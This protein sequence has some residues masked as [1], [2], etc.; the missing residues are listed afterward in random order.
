MSDVAL[1]AREKFSDPDWT[2][3]GERRARVA[4]DQ[5]RTLWINTGSLCNIECRNCYI[6]SSPEND[7]LAYITAREAARF[8]E[9]IASSRLPVREIG[10]TGGEPFMNPDIIAMAEDALARGHEVLILTNA[11]QP[12]QRPRLRSGLLGVARCLWRPAHAPGEPRPLHPRRCTRRSAGREHSPRRSTASTGSP[13]SG[14]SSRWP[15]APAGARARRICARASRRWRATGLAA[16]TRTIPRSS[17]CSRR[18]T[19]RPTCRRS[20]KPAGAS[21][22]RAPRDVMCASSRMVVK[23]KGAAGPVVLP[24]TLLPYDPGLRDGG[25][26]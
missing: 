4:L 13:G 7:R 9:E 3:Q 23:R 17:C 8:F 26:A 10:F 14:S 12:M 1:G 25:D 18:W 6:E 2:A 20:R 5:L 19:R 11:M 21:S 16:S 24:C 22:A 15:A